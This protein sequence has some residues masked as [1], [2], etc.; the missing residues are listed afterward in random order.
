MV[1]EA[2]AKGQLESLAK[3]MRI[4]SERWFPELH[5]GHVPLVQFY[6]L[7]LAGEA[8]EV[9]NEAKKIWR[10]VDGVYDNLGA[11]LADTFTYLLLLADELGV[12]LV[13]EYREKVR[14][15]ELRWGN[16]SS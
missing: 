14:I 5:D 8:G 11:E 9:A 13:K 6:A 2:T 16:G 3:E 12:D 10:N 7:G 15:N 4:N 1:L